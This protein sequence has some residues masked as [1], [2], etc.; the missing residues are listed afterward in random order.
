MRSIL[1]E[2][3]GEPADVLRLHDVPEL[4]APGTG[5][6]LIRVLSRPVHPGDLLG[7][8]GRYRAPGNTADVVPGGAR[9]GFEGAGVVEATGPNVT[10]TL[11]PGTRVAFFPARWAWSDHVLASAQFVTPV[12]NDV[13]D[14]VAGQLH[15]NP[16]TAL[17]LMR[18]V[19]DSGVREGNLVVL[20]AA[21]S[22]VGKLAM[23]LALRR[24]LSVIGI[25]RTDAGAASLQSSF[26]DVVVVSTEADDWRDR[27]RSAVTGKP[28][29]AVLDP[30]G[31]A[32]ASELFALLADGGSFIGY[33]DL[34]GEHI[35]ILPLSL[36]V[37]GLS[38]K[39]VSVGGWGS[40]PEAV[41]TADIA[42]AIELARTA[43]HLFPVAAVYDLAEVTA[44]VA[45]AEQPGRTGAVL[46]TSVRDHQRIE[47]S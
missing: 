45:H 42:T 28:V 34:S 47:S 9:L 19:D 20:S 3:Y 15:V 40:L 21:G 12:P 46:L 11:T 27:I 30:V 37:R 25:V 36:P 22:A 24:G 18:A 33:G 2:H 44:A 7:V 1:Y 39:G 8:R 6:V 14:A 5:E 31:G 16:L 17:M 35:S 29:R 43:S 13:S 38:M 41:R 10:A 4:P 32:L 26:P 23:T